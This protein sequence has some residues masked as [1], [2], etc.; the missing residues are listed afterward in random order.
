MKHHAVMLRDGGMAQSLKWT[1]AVSIVIGVFA[2]SISAQPPSIEELTAAFSAKV[3]GSA[4]FISGRDEEEAMRNS[5]AVLAG[6]SGFNKE[7][8]TQIDVNTEKKE[9]TVSIQDGVPRTARY[10]GDQGMIILPKGGGDVNFTPITL[11]S[12]LP[13]EDVT[14]WPMGNAPPNS[15]NAAPNVKSQLDAALDPVFHPDAQTA[16]VVVVYKGEIVA[17]RYASG[18]HRDMP[19]ESWSMGK[20]VTAILY[21]VLSHQEKS[22][23]PNRSAPIPE[24]QDAND[25]RKKIRVADLLRMSSGLRFS[26]RGDAPSTWTHAHPD[27]SYVYSGGINVYAFSANT[28]VE[29][30]PNT[31]G[32]YRNCDPL[33][34]GYLTKLA[35]EDRGENY[36]EFPRKHLFDKIGIRHMILETDRWGNF[37]STGY[38]YGSPRDWARLG[39]LMLQDGVWNGERI[40]PKGFVKFVSKP[41]P[42]WD[43][44]NYGGLFW[45]NANQRMNL[46]RS[47]YYMS[48]QG[49]QHVFIVPSHNLVIVR[50]GHQA[51]SR[52]LGPH[53]KETLGLIMDAV[54][55]D[56]R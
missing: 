37:I 32:R 56:W 6:F 18:A 24:W 41:A 39:L 27:H 26:S 11:E 45:V 2:Q 51:G 20:S 49:G 13:P 17:E 36:L 16:G 1:C 48:G 10:Y 46:P 40:L 8:F 23:K 29:H 12:S 21:G 15:S 35:V 25:P 54:D 30:P 34:I 31:V 43:P 9:V 22:W 52:A 5:V 14:P 44:P 50:M 38:D 4:I 47:A 33:L 55:P 42:A 3:L 53:L 28:E 7:D 19:L